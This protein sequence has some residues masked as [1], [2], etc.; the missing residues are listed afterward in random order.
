MALLKIS[1][2]QTV[3]AVSKTSKI[4]SA[5]RYKFEN[6]N[7]LQASFSDFVLINSLAKYA[8]YKEIPIPVIRNIIPVSPFTIIEIQFKIKQI[9]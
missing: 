2:I 4:N 5:N 7:K 8:K 1:I 6:L 9:Q 3:Y